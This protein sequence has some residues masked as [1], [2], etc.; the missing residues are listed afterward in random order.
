[1]H[2]K[3]YNL[4][5]ICMCTFML[6]A[7]FIAGYYAAN[8]IKPNQNYSKISYD[9]TF[10]LPNCSENEAK[11]SSY[12]LVTPSTTP[13]T[14]PTM[15]STPTPPTPTPSHK[16]AFLL[17]SYMGKLAVYKVG[18]N[19][20]VTLSYVLEVPIDLLPEADK[21]KLENGIKVENEDELLLLIEDFIS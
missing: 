5:V 17:K 11:A 14:I 12:S 16:E 15:T 20:E 6:I 8:F 10:D 19:N 2:R 1:M 21:T 9:Y 3:K 7:G 18:K 4:I 13:D